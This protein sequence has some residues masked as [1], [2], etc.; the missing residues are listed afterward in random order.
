MSVNINYFKTFVSFLQNKVQSGGTTTTDQFNFL[1]HQSQM[2]CFEKDRLVFL[3]TGESSD[4]LDWFLKTVPLSP[5][6]V[7]GYLPY[8]ADY[9]HTACVR[10]YYNKKERPVELITNKAWG[11]I[12][13]S[14]LQPATYRFPKYTEFSGEYRFLPK[15]I[16]IIM[17]DYWKEPTKPVWAY[18]IVNNVQVYNPTGSVDFEFG[19]FT[20]NRVA[21]EYLSFMGINLQSKQLAEF[22]E[23]FKQ[24]S[25]S[26][27]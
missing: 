10:S 23:Q 5:D 17:L 21:G 25:N 9:Q 12:Q 6:F 27:V 22:S 16:G 13:I 15:D 14:Q 20:L 2:S 4:F 1:A 19:E 18:T 11:D 3:K 7:T 24:Q 8:P 26:V